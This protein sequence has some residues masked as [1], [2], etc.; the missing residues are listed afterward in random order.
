MA[1]ILPFP[2]QYQRQQALPIDV[3]QQFETT[4]A[5]VAYLSSPRRY[6]GMQVYDIEADA[7]YML[8]GTKDAWREV[9]IGSNYQLLSEKGQANGYAP[10][11]S[12]AKLVNSYLDTINSNV[13]TFG[14]SVT[15]PT[16]VVNAQ[17]RLTAVSETAIPT[18]STSIAGLLSAI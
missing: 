2:L 12:S 5:R 13:G 7:T 6:A 9:A 15:V 3:D 1:T 8:N 10:L 11:N 16:L 18:A 17:G 14:N 4:A